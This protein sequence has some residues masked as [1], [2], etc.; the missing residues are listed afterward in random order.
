MRSGERQVESMMNRSQVKKG[1]E[2]SYSILKSFLGI[3][4]KVV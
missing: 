4:S 3:G 2:E 1:P